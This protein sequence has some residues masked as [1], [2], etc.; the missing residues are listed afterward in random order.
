MISVTISAALTSPPHHLKI[1]NSENLPIYEDNSR[2][3]RTFSLSLKVS[4]VGEMLSDYHLIDMKISIL[5]IR[6]I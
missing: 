4:V 5:I 2:K 6:F 3:M 1:Q